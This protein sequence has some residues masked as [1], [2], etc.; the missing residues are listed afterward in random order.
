M[1][2]P[3]NRGELERIG[4]AAWVTRI[5]HGEPGTVESRARRISSMKPHLDLVAATKAV[6]DLDSF[7]RGIDTHAPWPDP[8]RMKRLAAKTRELH[9]HLGSL[10]VHRPRVSIRIEFGPN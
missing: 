5:S 2:A 10:N 1:L 4:T 3:M 7:L 8:E 9:P 6:E